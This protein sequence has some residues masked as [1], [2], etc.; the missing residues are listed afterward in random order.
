MS[1]I[2]H[3]NGTHVFVTFHISN[4]TSLAR[5]KVDSPVTADMAVQ[6]L[7]N[8]TAVNTTLPFLIQIAANVSVSPI[9]HEVGRGNRNRTSNCNS[10]TSN[11]GTNCNNNFTNRLGLSDTVVAGIAVGLFLAG[12]LVGLIFMCV[13]ICCIYCWKS[14]S[15]YDVQ[16]KADASKAVKYAR[17]EDDVQFS[18]T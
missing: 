7:T 15:S 16:R 1:Q 17:Q 10:T 6:R 5:T 12:I 3:E 4:L 8:N 18:E 11:N 13:C 2:I 14:T 9:L